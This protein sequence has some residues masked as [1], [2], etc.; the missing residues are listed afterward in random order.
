M[1]KYTAGMRQFIPI[2]RQVKQICE[3][4]ADK[5][6]SLGKVRHGRD[7]WAPFGVLTMLNILTWVVV[8]WAR[9]PC[10]SSSS[11]TPV[12][13]SFFS[14]YFILQS[15]IYKQAKK[16]HKNVSKQNM[17]GTST[18]RKPPRRHQLVSLHRPSPPRSRRPQG[19]PRSCSLNL[20]FFSLPLFAFL[21]VCSIS[22]PQL[23]YHILQEE[24][25]DVFLLFPLLA[26]DTFLFSC[27]TH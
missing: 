26:S 21:D 22:Q 7:T 11:C 12:I 13:C 15:N 5:W 18:R 24:F 2:K 3:L 19:K 16:W 6:L 10:Q 17:V 27:I 20:E 9:S 8:T 25:N 23:E 1:Q 14:M 4:E